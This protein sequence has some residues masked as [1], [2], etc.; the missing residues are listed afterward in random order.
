KE[1]HIFVDGF[2]GPKG[3]LSIN[4]SPQRIFVNAWNNRVK[5]NWT[6]FHASLSNFESS[7]EFVVVRLRGGRSDQGEVLVTR[8][9]KTV[10]GKM[11]MEDADPDEAAI[12]TWN[13]FGLMDELVVLPRSLSDDELDQLYQRGKSG[14]SLA[15][16]PAAS[17]KAEK[18]AF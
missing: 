12:V 13:T 14:L 16:A 9:G 5:D 17:T 4:V 11:Q 2:D 6:G 3:T 1:F 10:R 15:A 18:G 8:N 7:W